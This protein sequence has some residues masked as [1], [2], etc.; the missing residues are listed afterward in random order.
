MIR[1]SLVVVTTLL[2]FSTMATSQAADTTTL[3]VSKPTLV[4]NLTSGPDDLHAVSMGLNFAGHGIAD[5][6]EVVVFFNVKSPPLARKDLADSVR[7]QDKEPIHT[8]ITDLL[9]NGAKMFVCPMC[10]EITEV[11]EDQ[12]T[13]G[14]ELIKD[15]KQLFDYLHSNSVV[16]SY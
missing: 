14:I 1:K 15:R 4:I 9:K 2:V 16:F 5:G 12:L 3:D 13:P 8:L 7:F 11:S 10:A 6:R